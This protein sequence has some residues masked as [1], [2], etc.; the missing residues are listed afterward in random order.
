L[1]RNEWKGHR[2]SHQADPLE[3]LSPTH[4]LGSGFR[5]LCWL[6]IKK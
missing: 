5:A 6:F 3:P 4:E 2:Q 1:E